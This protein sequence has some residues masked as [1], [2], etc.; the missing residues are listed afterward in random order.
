MLSHCRLDLALVFPGIAAVGMVRKG[1]RN[2]IFV[3]DFKGQ[4]KCLDV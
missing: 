2:A 4:A 1:N 3:V